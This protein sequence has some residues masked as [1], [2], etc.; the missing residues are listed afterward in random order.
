MLCACQVNETLLWGEESYTYTWDINANSGRFS[1]FLLLCIVMVILIII[2]VWGFIVDITAYRRKKLGQTKMYSKSG[3]MTKTNNL[4]IKLVKSDCCIVNFIRKIITWY[5][6]KFEVDTGFWIAQKCSAEMFEIFIQTTALL[7]YNGYILF[8]SSNEVALAHKPQ[9][10]KLFAIFLSMNSIFVC[11]IW[12]FYAFKPLICHGFV[13][14]LVLYSLDVIFDIFYALFPLIMVAQESAD[15]EVALGYLQT[16]D[17]LSFFGFI[18]LF[19]KIINQINIIRTTFW[20]AFFPLAFLISSSYSFLSQA[21]YQLKRYYGSKF[22]AAN[23][24]V[25]TPTVGSQVSQIMALAPINT[26]NSWII[27]GTKQRSET[28]RKLSISIIALIFGIYGV[29][30]LPLVFTH[31]DQSMTY[32][33]SITEELYKLEEDLSD[34]NSTINLTVN[35]N[36][37]MYLSEQRQQILDAH[38]ELFL[39]NYCDYSVYPFGTDDDGNPLCDCRKF[40]GDRLETNRLFATK[41]AL[42]GIP[43][44][45]KY[46]NVDLVDALSG[47]LLNW[48]ML[49]KF[50]WRDTIRIYTDNAKFCEG[51]SCYPKQ[52]NLTNDM[53]GATKMRVFEI[54]N[55][56]SVYIGEGIGNWKLLSYFKWSENPG[57]RIDDEYGLPDSFAT[58]TEM[59]YIELSE[60]AEITQFPWQVC[61]FTKLQ[62]LDLDATSIK[63][64]PRCILG[65]TKLQSISFGFCPFIASFPIELFDNDHFIDLRELNAIVLTQLTLD[66]LMRSNNFSNFDEFDAAFSYDPDKDTQYWFDSA[67]FC[68]DFI[69]MEN[70]SES[71]FLEW[72]VNENV[73]EP[74]CGESNSGIANVDKC[75]TYE[76][77]DGRCD[78][79]CRTAQCAWDGG[80]CI[81]LCECWDNQTL[82]GDGNCDIAC[83]TTNCLWDGYD[84]LPLGYDPQECIDTYELGLHNCNVSWVG[85]RWCDNNCKYVSE[86]GNDLD[87]CQ[88]GNGRYNSCGRDY[89]CGQVYDIFNNVASQFS[90]D[91]QID[92]SEIDAWW[93]IAIAIGGPRDRSK[94]S[95]RSPT[96]LIFF[97]TSWIS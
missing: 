61:N 12:L 63:S 6:T 15:F 23:N 39:Y 37:G 48:K 33:S 7:Y 93:E 9:Y 10:I 1:G 92:Q 58:L 22:A 96:S 18:K 25:N 77:Q 78:A 59:K 41:N 54:A 28:M 89:Q 43:S 34:P 24:K 29:I 8:S 20:A 36:T 90:A 19:C 70:N 97:Q 17:P 45:Q 42:L 80:D 26:T 55:Q 21:R 11:I 88:D 14:Q 79:L 67:A 32:C 72:I 2:Y 46:F 83:N 75:L 57:F 69:E 91:N 13:F 56:P 51:G 84:C 47:M 35:G 81:M 73:C 62:G 31:F 27:T 52:F 44:L 40:S 53:F 85:D 76:Y 74:S 87:D 30:L 60:I 3:C 71:K 68:N 65:L 82:L 49:E 95:G 5:W 94:K 86:C 16:D 66:A 4:I 50:R 64:I 38:P